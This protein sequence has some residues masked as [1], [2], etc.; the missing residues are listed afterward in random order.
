[1]PVRNWQ[2]GI[3]RISVESW[4]HLSK[5]VAP[6]EMPFGKLVARPI[7][8]WKN[9]GLTDYP[10]VVKNEKGDTIRCRLPY[11]CQITPYLHVKLRPDWWLA[12]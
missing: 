1:M 5:I 8:M 6:N 4:E 11:N 12:C 9:G 3:C 7:P 2:V 10:E